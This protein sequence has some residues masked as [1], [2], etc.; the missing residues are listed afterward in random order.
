MCVTA[1][2]SD[3]A[4]GSLHDGP[5]VRTVV[6]F[7]GCGLRCK[8]CHNPETLAKASEIL[9]ASSKCIACGN[10][11]QVCPQHHI[12]EENRMVF[13]RE[14][15]TVCGKCVQA[16]PTL[17]L[18]VCGKEMDADAIFSEIK[19]D[20]P[21]Y[22]HSHG[23]VTFSGG[24]CLLQPEA[25]A[26]LAQR[27]QTLGI[28]TA[29]ES[30]LHVPWDNVAQVLPYIDLFYA[31]L[32][33]ADPD[34]HRHYT[35]QDNHLILS[36][37]QKL[38]THHKNIIVRIPVIPGVNDTE[39]DWNGFA[40]IL[41]NLGSGVQQVELLKYNILGASKYSS[42]GRS[43]TKFSETAQSDQEMK[44]LCSALEQRCQIPCSF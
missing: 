27:C 12:I 33:L 24:E 8:W 42:I 31:D 7:K 38:S 9:F 14:G 17:A 30:A 18:T 19:K 3:I 29:V 1:Q 13:A 21:Y 44:Q 11:I 15:C 36:N 43:F 25:V 5:G 34:K 16:C 28:S 32:K 41:Q 10:C 20:L 23:G 2:I 26:H 22:T 40:E 39:E 37:L 4:R 35:G 6:Y